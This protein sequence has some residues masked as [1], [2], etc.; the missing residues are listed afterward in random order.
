M[1]DTYDKE[2][3]RQWHTTER[4]PRIDQLSFGCLQRIADACEKMAASYDAMRADRDRWKGSAEYRQRRIEELK[5]SNAA[6]RGHIGLL[7]RG[8][9]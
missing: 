7:K 8:G 2:S 5:H 6:L 4:V 3:R 1:S 9:S